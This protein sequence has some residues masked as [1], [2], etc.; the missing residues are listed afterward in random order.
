MAAKITPSIVL[1]NRA[2]ASAHSLLALLREP[3]SEPIEISASDPVH[4]IE[5]HIINLTAPG[6]EELPGNY[7]S[8]LERCIYEAALKAAAASPGDRPRRRPNRRHEVQIATLQ[9]RRARRPPTSGAWLCA[10]GHVQL[11]SITPAFLTS[12]IPNMLPF[13]ASRDHS[14]IA[15]RCA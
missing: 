4:R 8:P 15:T 13:N 2:R 10:S 11:R 6:A 14:R 3:V 7:F 12:R 5:I 1:H 9:S